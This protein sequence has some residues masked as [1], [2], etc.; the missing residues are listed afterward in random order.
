MPSQGTLL[1]TPPMGGSARALHPDAGMP[2]WVKALALVV[3]AVALIWVATQVFSCGAPQ[4]AQ[5]ADD[6]A[7]APATPATLEQR[8]ASYEPYIDPEPTDMEALPDSTTT[9]GFVLSGQ[10]DADVP[11]LGDVSTTAINAAMR[12]FLDDGFDVAYVL[13]DIETGRGFARNVDEPIYGASSFKG[14]FCTFVAETYVDSGEVALSEIKDSLFNAI[15]YSDNGTY[16]AMR[17][18]FSNDR[19]VQ[20]LGD[21]GVGSRVAYDTDYPTYT[22][23]DLA[24]LWME[25]YDYLEGGT[26]AAEAM[27]GYFGTTKT[28]FMRNA[29]IAVEPASDVDVAMDESAVAEEGSSLATLGDSISNV[30]VEAVEKATADDVEVFDK[31]GWYPRD[32]ADI[33]AIVDAGIVSCNGRDYLLCVMTDMPWT[34][35][36]QETAEELIKAVFD[37]RRDLA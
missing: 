35:P 31:A 4:A 11:V 6:E 28:S 7:A 8:L 3:A 23:R 22:A 36:N 26:A 33:P 14:P 18:R 32:D 5:E 15:V 12:P 24:K 27:I 25:T 2:G 17:V 30:L 21:L 1:Q 29:M 34:E 19:L 9:E 13:M 37:A 10:E 16:E 20:W